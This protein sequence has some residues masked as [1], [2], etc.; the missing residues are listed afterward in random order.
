MARLPYVDQQSAPPDVQAIFK[1][2]EHAAVAQFGRPFVLNVMRA[3]AHAPVLLRRISSLG[4]AMLNDLT[5]DPRLRELAVLQ[6][7]RVNRCD[8]GFQQHVALAKGVGLN[9]KQIANVGAYRSYPYYSE[10]ERVVLE[11]AEVVTKDLTVSDDL[12][13]RVRAQF[14]DQQLVELTMVIAY[15][16]MMSR[17]LIPLQVEVEEATQP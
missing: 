16:N 11:Y 7:F 17:F 12:F 9:D 10:V 3:L 8:Y 2:L 6:L 15:W 13:A 14:N 5:L 4:N 1:R